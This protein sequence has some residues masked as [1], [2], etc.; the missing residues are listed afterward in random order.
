M[1]LGGMAARS[2]RACRE[3]RHVPF[4]SGAAGT[5]WLA[6]RVIT[7]GEAIRGSSPPALP[8]AWWRCRRASIGGFPFGQRSRTLAETLAS[9]R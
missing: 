5:T 3:N 1:P 2:A 7:S 9:P 4:R 6:D 8:S